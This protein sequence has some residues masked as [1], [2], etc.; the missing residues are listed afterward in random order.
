MDERVVTITEGKVEIA[1][2]HFL[3]MTAQPNASQVRSIVDG[4]PRQCVEVIVAAAERLVDL[5]DV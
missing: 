2:P 3:E 4:S 1:P 5:L